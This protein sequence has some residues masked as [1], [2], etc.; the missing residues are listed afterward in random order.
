[1]PEEGIV[2]LFDIKQFDTQHKKQHSVEISN[3]PGAVRRARASRAR[4]VRARIA[5]Q[6]KER[7]ALFAGGHRPR[8]VY[9]GTLR[10][11]NG[12]PK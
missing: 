7:I 12:S 2:K 10:I 6:S 5:R 8:G 3:R 11:F 4:D 1:L 9:A